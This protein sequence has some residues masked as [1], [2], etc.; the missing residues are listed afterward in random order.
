M[1]RRAERGVV[2][3]MSLIFLVVISLVAAL[4]VRRSISGEQVSKALRTNAVAFQAAE[5]ALRYCEDQIL[6]T[7]KIPKGAAQWEPHPA[8]LDGT[9]PVLWRDRANWEPGTS[10]SVEM[11]GGMVDSQDPAARALPTPPRCMV[12]SMWL[13]GDAERREAFL[14]TAVGFSPDYR[15]GASGIPDSGGEVWL[16]STIAA[17]ARGK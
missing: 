17:G 2:L 16:Q 11:A 13:P 5:T 7:G 4:A 10:A 8:P 1:S 3:I 9:A 15:L 6:R 14:I 12:E